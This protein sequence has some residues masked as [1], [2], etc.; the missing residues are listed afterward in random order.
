M[1]SFIPFRRVSTI[2]TAQAEWSSLR[3]EKKNTYCTYKNVSDKE[4]KYLL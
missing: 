2:P 4:I 1:S 3:H